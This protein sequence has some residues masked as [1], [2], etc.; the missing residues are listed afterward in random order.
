MDVQSTRDVVMW[1]P[2]WLPMPCTLVR[3]VQEKKKKK[4]TVRAT[5]SSFHFEARPAAAT[6]HAAAANV[7]QDEVNFRGRCCTRVVVHPDCTDSNSITLS[8]H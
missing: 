3:N 1:I 6:V 8:S 2:E 4:V 7:R 5:C